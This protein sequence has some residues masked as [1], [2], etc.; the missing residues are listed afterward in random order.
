[1]RMPVTGDTRLRHLEQRAAD[2]VAVSNADLCIRQAIDGKVFA[3]LP[4][5]EVVSSQ[6]ALPIP[7]GIHLIDKYRPA[8]AAMTIQV[9]LSVTVDVEPAHHARALNGRLP[10]AGMNRLALP[11]DVARQAHID[12]KQESHHVS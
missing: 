6:M 7:I 12:R 10:D 5:N 9:T 11:G 8:F 3:E 1:M 2:P 4:I